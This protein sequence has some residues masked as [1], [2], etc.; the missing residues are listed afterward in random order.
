MRIGQTQ[1]PG[2]T[3]ESV[4][5]QERKKE[6][7]LHGETRIQSAIIQ[8]QKVNLSVTCSHFES[9]GL[10]RQLKGLSFL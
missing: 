3:D 10:T 6:V 9:K 8:S 2:D 1:S 5:A 7:S 4:P